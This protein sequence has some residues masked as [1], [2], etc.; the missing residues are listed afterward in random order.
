MKTERKRTLKGTVLFT[1]VSVMALMIIVLTSTLAMATAANR[2]AHKSYASSQT[3]YT[4]RAAIDSIL[5]AMSADKD[6]AN[7][8]G[9]IKSAA[10]N[11]DVIVDMQ[12]PSLG[13]I[14][15][16]RVEYAG[17]KQMYDPE[18]KKWV[19]KT[20]LKVTADV[21]LNGETTTISSHVIIDPVGGGGGGGGAPFV[22]MGQAEAKNHVNGFGG[23]FLGMGINDMS[24]GEY[25]KKIKDGTIDDL[26]GEPTALKKVNGEWQYWSGDTFDVGRDYD[27]YEAPFVINGSCNVNTKLSCIIQKYGTGMVVWGDMETHAK[28]CLNITS[29]GGAAGDKEGT[30]NVWVDKDNAGPRAL[31]FIETPYLYVDGKLDFIDGVEGIGSGNIPLNIFCGSIYNGSNNFEFKADVYC[32]DEDAKSVINTT[33]GKLYNWS[34]SV[35]KG[36]LSY[37][38]VGGAFNSKGNLEVNGNGCEFKGDVRVAGDVTFNGNVTVNG[39]LVVGGHLQNNG[40]LIVTGN[41]YVDSASGNNITAG[42]KSLKTGYKEIDEECIPVVRY[43]NFGWAK[44]AILEQGAGKYNAI[45][46]GNDEFEFTYYEFDWQVGDAIWNANFVQS[47]SGVNSG[48][49]FDYVKDAKDGGSIPTYAVVIDTNTNK[50]VDNPGKAYSMSGIK[51]KGNPVNSVASY[52]TDI[53]PQLAERGV[54]LGLEQ[55]TDG[56]GHLIDID[57]T[58][59]LTTVPEYTSKW[60]LKDNADKVEPVKGKKINISTTDEIT[61]SVLIE[62]THFQGNGKKITIKRPAGEGELWVYLKNSTIESTTFEIDDSDAN[63]QGTVNFYVEGHCGL[64]NGVKIYTTSFKS[65]LDSGD[66]FE[67][68]SDRKEH[69]YLSQTTNVM[70]IPCVKM[71]SA[72]DEHLN[73]PNVNDRDTTLNINNGFF[74]TGF[75]VSPYLTLIADTVPTTYD[76]EILSHCYYDGALLSKVNKTAS[77]LSRISVVGCMDI[78]QLTTTPGGSGNNLTVLYINEN[79]SGEG[80]KTAANGKF[81]YAA[82]DYDAY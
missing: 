28:D 11:F 25:F 70:P 80:T 76:T 19:K 50:P 20:L 81:S 73:E 2:R 41:V 44:P 29:F 68:L 26:T 21:T 34:N 33:G 45:P 23:T 22:T 64:C 47:M 31:S 66:N 49:I 43:G 78:H 5:A 8:V 62:S 18:Q 75:I 32:M 42:S 1:V 12:D 63:C 9:G 24:A 55:A 79:D 77:G 36:G 57:Q 30:I 27:A 4:A 52:G 10:G 16:A 39:D 35:W 53:Y 69:G 65:L 40:N 3:S 67:I 14:D 51:F 60:S 7:A 38:A 59:L 82:V 54:L 46:I 71:Y 17:V 56:E 6:F 74:F 61:E 15:K 13:T 48:N 58:K 37:S 72:G